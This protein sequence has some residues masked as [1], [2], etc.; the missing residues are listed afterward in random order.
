MGILHQDYKDNDDNHLSQEEFEQVKQFC[1]VNKLV[2]ETAPNTPELTDLGWHVMQIMM[3]IEPEASI[4]LCTE[5]MAARLGT[6]FER[7]AEATSGQI[8]LDL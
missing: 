8:R 2:I 7:L 4:S 3:Y 1:L 5:M 6:F